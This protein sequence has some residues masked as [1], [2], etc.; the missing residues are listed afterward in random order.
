MTIGIFPINLARS[1]ERWARLLPQLKLLSWPIVRIEAY[2]GEKEVFDPSLVNHRAYEQFFGKKI[3]PGTLACSLSHHKAWESFLNTRHDW[4]LILE[5]DACFKASVLDR[6]VKATIRVPGWDI[7]G[8]QLNHKGC[9][10]PLKTVDQGVLCLYLFPVSGAACYLLS[11]SAAE[12]LLERALPIRNPIDHYQIES[13]HHGLVF[14]GF[15]PRPVTQGDAPSMIQAIGRE[16]RFEQGRLDKVVRSLCVVGRALACFAHGL[17]CWGRY[18]MASF[19]R[20]FKD[21]IIIKK[22]EKYQKK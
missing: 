9:P 16:H 2:D 17:F 4:G 10:L 14:V 19:R 20:H 21:A 8:F 22:S 15:E 12:K 3:G 6:A 7:C 1:P 5:D 13:W 11:R 18:H